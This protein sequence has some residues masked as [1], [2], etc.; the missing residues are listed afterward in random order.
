MPFDSS[1]SWSYDPAQSTGSYGID[2]VQQRNPHVHA[3][4]DM[5]QFPMN[6]QH[7]ATYLGHGHEH[8]PGASGSS[9]RGSMQ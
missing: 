8:N 1:F 5:L 9:G 3:V 6:P 4:P 7:I 2:Q